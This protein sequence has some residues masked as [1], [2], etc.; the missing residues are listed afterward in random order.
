MKKRPLLWYFILAFAITWGIG[1]FFFAFP[2]QVAAL[3]GKTSSYNP[4]FI[5]AVYAPSISALI[6]TG[7]T[8]GRSGISEILRKFIRFRVGFQWYLVVLAGIPAIGLA[9]AL[10]SGTFPAIQMNRW[11]L[12]AP[13]LVNLVITGPLGEEL[14]WRG[15][16]LPRM[17]KKWNALV[18]SLILGVIWGVWHLPAFFAAGTPQSGLSL[19]AFMLGA[20]VLSVIAAWIYINT[21]SLFLTFLMHLAANFSLTVLGA[22]L[23][24]FSVGLLVAAVGIVIAAGPRYFS[25]PKV[26]AAD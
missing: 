4:L 16:A 15:F 7:V 22:P 18:S 3:F 17:L 25:R 5:L 12:L 8:Q 21:G 26:S 11:D 24:A 9:A 23:M 10:V 19:P 1:V 20:V 14:G 6:V 2:A 13:V